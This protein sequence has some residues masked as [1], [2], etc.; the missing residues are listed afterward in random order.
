M[1][2]RKISQKRPNTM[3]ADCA[4][5]ARDFRLEGERVA[6][7]LLELPALGEKALIGITAESR[8]DDSP[9]H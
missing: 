9:T 2:Q 7:V 8:C 4:D 6:G 3:K 5:W 1:G